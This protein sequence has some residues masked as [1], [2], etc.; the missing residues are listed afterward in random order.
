MQGKIVSV[1]RS[2]GHTFSKERCEA[3]RIVAGLGVEGDAHAG[4]TVKHRYLVRKNPK[5]PN[6][7]QVHL[8]QAELFE[9][10]HAKG[11]EV[12]PGEMGEN[13]TTSGVDLLSLPLGAKLHLGEQAVVEVTGLR[14]PCT[15]MDGLRPGLMKACTGRE[16]DGSLVRKAGIM[17]IAVVGG[18]VAV[19]DAIAVELPAGEWVKLGPV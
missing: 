18:V 5:A 13:V 1:S 11:I 14:T 8:L 17:A 3:I 10:L 9:E 12:T 2:A 16:A 15:Q 19:E 6:L 4:V 7:C